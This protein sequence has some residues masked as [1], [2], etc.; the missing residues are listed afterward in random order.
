MLWNPYKS[1][2]ESKWGR[3]NEN[4]WLWAGDSQGKTAMATKH[5]QRCPTSLVVTETQ[6]ETSWSY[7]TLVRWA[8]SRRGKGGSHNPGGTPGWEPPPG[9]PLVTSSEEERQKPIFRD[10]PETLLRVSIIKTVRK[11]SMQQKHWGPRAARR[12]RKSFYIQ[13]NLRSRK[14]NESEIY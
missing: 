8:M 10:T 14:R 6:T 11:C 3:G 12:R 7:H 9:T 5:P 2:R 1:A 13:W 4:V